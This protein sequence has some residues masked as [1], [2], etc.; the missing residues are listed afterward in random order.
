M[1]KILVLITMI[2]ILSILTGC[3][4]I[5]ENVVSPIHDD[6][7]T[8]EYSEDVR[9]VPITRQHIKDGSING[10]DIARYVDLDTGV[11][12]IYTEKYLN[13]YG[14]TWEISV[15]PDGTPVTYAGLEEIRK[16][17]NWEQK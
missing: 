2:T 13:G 14:T 17:Y 16:Q 8:Y 3:G 5:L 11:I 9:Y 7:N 10:F 15:N 1:K 12:Y 6:I 4:K